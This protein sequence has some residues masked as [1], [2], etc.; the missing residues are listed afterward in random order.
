M[1][2][3]TKTTQQ[4]HVQ[5]MY[6]TKMPPKTQITTTLPL[7]IMAFVSPLWSHLANLSAAAERSQVTAVA[8]HQLRPRSP[9]WWRSDH[10][11]EG[12]SPERGIGE[13]AVVHP[14][15]KVWNHNVSYHYNPNISSA[16]LELLHTVLL[17][18]A[19]AT[20]EPFSAATRLPWDSWLTT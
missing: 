19:H 16:L 2:E 13:T 6:T 3:P 5:C 4:F 17:L 7:A 10:N 1:K 18:V 12:C 9:A 15:L 14:W 11:H 8:H 20:L